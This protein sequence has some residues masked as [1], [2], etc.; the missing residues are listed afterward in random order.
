[1]FRCVCVCV[2]FVVVF[3]SQKLMLVNKFA[4]LLK[5]LPL[6]QKITTFEVSSSFLKKPFYHANV[7]IFKQNE[8]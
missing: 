2:F 1:M 6:K 4:A 5:L 7:N 3:F 8:H